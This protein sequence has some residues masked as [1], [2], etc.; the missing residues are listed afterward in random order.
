VT[1]GARRRALVVDDEVPLAHLVSSYLENAGFE[2]A[3]AFDGPSAVGCARSF[4]P[5]IV[6]LDLGLPGRGGIAVCRE[7]R[8][9]SDCYVIML[10]AR[11]TEA[12]K[13]AGLAIGA[14]DYITKPFSPRELVARAEVMLRRPRREVPPASA[15]EPLAFGD[16]LIDLDGRELRLR[17]ARGHPHRVLPAGHVGDT[18]RT[19]LQPPG[20]DRRGLGRQL[21]R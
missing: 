17:G 8:A 14:D 2:V 6:I 7:L 4:D 9:F 10:T 20:S 16:L 11:T 21:G 18:P 3:Q 1:S 12:D 15:L 13:L 5:D 19:R